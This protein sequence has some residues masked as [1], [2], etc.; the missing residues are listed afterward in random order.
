VARAEPTP[1]PGA[2]DA[3]FPVYADGRIVPAGTPVVC[4]ED[5]GFLLGLSVYD[6]LLYA[7]GC[8]Y[9]VA[10][11]VERLHRGASELGIPWPPPWDPVEA[12]LA[13][14]DAVGEREAALRITLSRGVPGRGPTLVVTPRALDVPPEPGV[15]VFVSGRSKLGGDPLENLKST[16]RL[17]NVLAREEAVRRGAWEAILCN[18]DG[19]YSEGTVSNFWIVHDGA[20]RTPP[21]ERGCLQGIVRERIL[22]EL[23]ERPL[24]VEEAG[25]ERRV[26][27]EVAR[28]EPRHVERASEAFLSNT[29]GRV[30]PILEV[31]GA[32]GPVRRGL[33]GSAGPVTRALRARVAEVERRYRESRENV[34]RARAR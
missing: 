32:G 27:V 19:D 17:R 22:G 29:T 28:V 8:I 26:A 33:P 15:A 10:E 7:D 5:L 11:H 16:N 1:H 25:R 9:F 6:T 12:L 14:A 24:T 3:G 13:T 2:S 34:L 31:L 21:T 18:H 30:T 20:L 4:G 23:A